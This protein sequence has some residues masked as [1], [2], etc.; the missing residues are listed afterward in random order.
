MNL[1][2]F[3]KKNWVHFA[4]AGIF[5]IVCAMYF[6]LQLTGYG[7]KQHDIEQ[8]IGM[9]HEIAD[10][11]EHHD[12][13]EP[14][15]TNSMFGGMPATQISLIHP[16]NYFA[17]I[18]SGFCKLFPSPMG[19]VLLYMIGF[20]LML[21]MMRVNN[22]VSIIGSVIYAFLSYQIIILQAGHNSK[23]I[24]IAYMAPVIGAF[25]LA[26]RR[27]W[28]W[29]ALLSAIFMSFE[30]A[31][32]H[33]QVTYYLGILLVG[34]GIAEVVRV[35]KNKEFA[36]F[37]KATLGIIVGYG[38]ALVINYG[39]ISMTNQYAKYSI[40]GGND[41][42]IAADGTSNSTT[43][44]KGLDREYVTQ[45]SYG[46]GET[47]SFISPYVKGAGS[48]R[49]SDSQFADKVEESD[50]SAEQKEQVMN[51]NAYWGEQPATSGP[52]Y[53]G[54]ILVFLAL[55]GL[56][57]IKDASKWA[58]LGVTI[59]TVMLSWGK[60]YMGLTNW[61]LD[62]V[63]GY[64]KFRAVTII[65]IIAELCIPLLAV[66]L[67][68]KLI[69]ERDE[70]KAN[71]KPF[72]IT[73]A[74]FFVLLL[75]MKFVGVNKSYLSSSER[76][77]SAIEAQLDQIRPMIQQQIMEM[78]DEQAA[79]NNI[80]KND[81]QA[82]NAIIEGEIQ[83]RRDAYTDG[84]A[85]AQQMREQVYNSS[86]NRSILFFLLAIGCLFIYFRTAVSAVISLGA[87]G[88]FALIDVLTVTSNYLNNSDVEGQYKYWVP[89][90]ETLYPVQAEQA[91][92]EIMQMET[93]LN[94]ELKQLV[95]KGKAEG[96]AKANSL[97]AVGVEA[98]NIEK[99]YAF[100]AL[101]RNTNYRVYEPQAGFSSSR[102]SYFH[103]S[104]G[105]YHGAKLR[106]IQNL[107]EFHI[108]KSNNKVFDM[109]NVKYFLQK[110]EQGLIVQPN[111]TAL[112]NA[113]FV[114]NSNIV[115][116]ANT[117]IL[118]LG[119]KF[120][121]ENIGDG[122]LIINGEAKK[123]A[124]EFGSVRL[125]YLRRGFP[126]T[127]DIPLSNGV[128]K[129]AEIVFVQDTK[130]Q[131]NLIMKQ[132][133]DQDTTKSFTGLVTFKV[134]SSFNPIE[135]VVISAKEAKKLKARKWNGEGK[136]R[137]IS[138][139]PNK[140]V[141]EVNASD[142][143]MAVFS[144]V[145]YPDGWTATIDGK[146]ADIVKVNYVLRGLEVPKGKYKIEFTFD[147]PDFYQYNQISRI[148]SIFLILLTAGM[149]VIILRKKQK[150]NPAA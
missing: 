145:Y 86:V 3:F 123:S 20:Y 11:R 116:D 44:T 8:H 50:L 63:P 140:L 119:S 51:T 148:V 53:I 22:W 71:L 144:E 139:A 77:D 80:N 135:E 92:L 10:Y 84:L 143:G 90:L 78:P 41:L 72:Y 6:N 33:L 89:K 37:G 121:M 38:L 31:A 1:S 32:N 136:I 68:H 150:S 9:S 48:M 115:P 15:W 43:Q 65:L 69:Q 62:N 114:R 112:G 17:K 60:N 79:A 66:L 142:A 101:T 27:S 137:M 42:T 105:G 124:D 109:L 149:A 82:V 36:K 55:L 21:M 81:P 74:A 85:A 40:R 39:N 103:K 18:T 64:D 91:D 67:L 34:L 29:G 99:A 106:T 108:Y 146:P 104:L 75:G 120:H 70:I 129:G 118:S 76:D 102:T 7:L 126:D 111:E 24:A 96:R 95:E 5:L 14:L 93:E 13:Q 56:V 45:Y 87:L 132:G 47:F 131:P 12:G 58:L 94:P 110:T 16:G 128:P 122:Q 113:W 83:S 107:A 98:K 23:G 54:V 28:I 97:G 130:G 4:A 2:S 26:Y 133:F 88:V 19:I 35:I 49:F 100:A 138:Y 61:F 52:V 141:Y 117:E 25:Y 57:Y 125:Q 46:M 59:L 127:L 73:A 147:Q 134:T 30:L